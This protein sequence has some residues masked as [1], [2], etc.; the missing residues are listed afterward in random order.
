M[1]TFSNKKILITGFHSYIGQC[2][3]EKL[4]ERKNHIICTKSPQSKDT[5]ADR[6]LVKKIDMVK[7]DITNLDSVRAVVN[8]SQADII[9]HL[10]AYTNADRDV[11]ILDQCMRVNALG[12]SNLLQALKDTTYQRI[13]NISST[14]VYGNIDVPFQEDQLPHPISPYGISKLTAEHVCNFYHGMYNSP[15]VNLR[16]AMSYG[17]RQP[18]HKLLPF[19]IKYCVEKK[20]LKLT[21]GLQ[22]RDFV[23]VSDVVD[24]MLRAAIK[25]TAIGETFNVGTGIETPIRDLVMMVKKYVGQSGKITFGA[26]PTK[27]GEIMKM[28]VSYDKAKRVLG[29]KPKVDLE[30]G[31][32]KMIAWYTK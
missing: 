23:Y 26:M 31:L 24:A 18:Q 25:P 11:N 21:E 15:I 6:E 8:A 28:K 13:V 14:E 2:L 32:K 20:E 12:T 27:Q 3:I 4:L 5:A 7:M 1:N 9:F 30:I 17:I 22:T 19:L 10:A 16:L 29:W